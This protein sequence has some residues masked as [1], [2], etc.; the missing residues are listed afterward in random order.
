MWR[1]GWA[2]L[3]TR[4]GVVICCVGDFVGL[5]I[6]ISWVEDLVG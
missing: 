5:E 2:G 3:E 1:F 4:A 6:G